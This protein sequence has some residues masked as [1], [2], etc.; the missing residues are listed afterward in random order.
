MKLQINKFF[1]K[2]PITKIKNQKNK[3]LIWNS[4]KREDQPVIFRVGER[5]KR[6]KDSPLTNHVISADT[7]LITRRERSDASNNI[8]KGQFQ[9]PRDVTHDI[10]NMQTPLTRQYLFGLKIIIYK[11]KKI[12]VPLM[13]LNFTNKPIWKNQNAPLCMA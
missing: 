1:I 4:K 11:T 12:K 6:K 10:E 9:P 2:E 7:H 5:K 13:I 3:N 8:M